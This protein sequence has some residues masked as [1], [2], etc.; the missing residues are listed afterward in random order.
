[1]KS[2]FFAKYFFPAYYIMKFQIGG[3]ERS[4]GNIL[5]IGD[6]DNQVNL[7]ENRKKYLQKL[8]KVS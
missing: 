3:T 5:N 2:F 4:I 7:N 1:M 8:I 6:K